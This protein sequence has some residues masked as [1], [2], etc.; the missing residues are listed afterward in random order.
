MDGL[1]ANEQDKCGSASGNQKDNPGEE[2]DSDATT[3]EHGSPNRTPPLF[4]E[5]A[6]EEPAS[7]LSTASSTSVETVYEFDPDH[8]GVPQ[9]QPCFKNGIHYTP[10]GLKR[11]YQKKDKGGKR[12]KL[13]FDLD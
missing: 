1:P 6:S 12:R 13:N 5:P 10:L 2:Y 4:T 8:P 7:T 9:T 3:L 11:T